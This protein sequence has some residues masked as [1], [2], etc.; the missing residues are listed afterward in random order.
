M[1]FVFFPI[2]LLFS[3]TITKRH[4]GPGYYVEWKS[5]SEKSNA[6]LMTIDSTSKLVIETNNTIETVKTEE[7]NISAPAIIQFEEQS[8]VEEQ[9]LTNLL[10]LKQDQL[11]NSEETVI[12]S[13]EYQIMQKI[14]QKD[15]DEITHKKMQK[16]TW[17]SLLFFLLLGIMTAIFSISEFLLTVGAGAVLFALALGMFITSLIAVIRIMRNPTLYKNRVLSFTIF[18]FSCTFLA[19]GLILFLAVGLSEINFF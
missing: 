4:F 8:L 18:F 9:D 3:C 12:Q 10:D 16:N 17:I 2:A 15:D 14:D 6:S 1:L 11:P 5:S 7:S 19:V 13:E